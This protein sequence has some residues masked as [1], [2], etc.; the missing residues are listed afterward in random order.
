LLDEV[1]KYGDGVKLWGYVT[2]NVQPLCVEFWSFAQSY[3]CK[4]FGIT[5]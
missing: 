4:L 3:L 5:R 2:T 1:L